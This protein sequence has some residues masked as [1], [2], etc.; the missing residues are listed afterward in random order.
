M[1]I[2]EFIKEL[3]AFDAKIE[4]VES[5]PFETKIDLDQQLTELHIIKSMA[6]FD[7]IREKLDLIEVKEIEPEVIGE[8]PDVFLPDDVES[9]DKDS[10]K[11][12][13]TIKEMEAILK[14]GGVKGYSKLNEDELV[15]LLIKNKLV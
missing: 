11:K 10:I 12:K 15:D 3:E 1:S 13:Y 5:L 9:P 6:V 2:K 14:E 7:I 4:G 8:E